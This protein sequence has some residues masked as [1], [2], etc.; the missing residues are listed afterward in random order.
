MFDRTIL[1][2]VTRIK[3]YSIDQKLAIRLEVD[4]GLTFDNIRHCKYAGADTYAGWSLIKGETLA[5]IMQ[6]YAALK[7]HIAEDENG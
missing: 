7:L 4:G 3:Q 1:S 5:E 6:N 2:K